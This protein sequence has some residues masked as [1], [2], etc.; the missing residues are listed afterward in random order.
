MKTQILINFQHQGHYN[1]R[2]QD[3]KITI[4]FSLRLY[5]SGEI[6]LLQL[7]LFEKVYLF[8]VQTGC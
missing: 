5:V 2:K 8:M 7:N 1:L 4:L 3:R 6:K